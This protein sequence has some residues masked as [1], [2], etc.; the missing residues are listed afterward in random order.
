MLN[1]VYTM[2][3]VSAAVLVCSCAQSVDADKSVYDE[4]IPA[5]FFRA[6]VSDTKT[7]LKSGEKIFWLPSDKLSIYDGTS[8][9]T[10]GNDLTEASAS[11]DFSV[12]SGSVAEGDVSYAALYPASALYSWN[13]SGYDVSF[14]VPAVQTAEPGAIADGLDLLL[15]RSDSRSLSFTH[16]MSALKFTIDENSPYITG[17]A[18]TASVKLAARFGYKYSGSIE[19]RAS[20]SNTVT[21]KMEDDGVF[22]EGDYYIMIPAR[23]YSAALTVTFTDDLGNTAERTISAGKT[24]VAGTIYP[25]GTVSGLDLHVPFDANTVSAASISSELESK[26]SDFRSAAKKPAKTNSVWI[27]SS[28]YNAYSDKAALAARLSLLGF[29]SVYLSPGAAKINTPADD[30]KTFICECS[31]YRI[32]VFYSALDDNTQFVSYN[33]AAVN[34]LLAFN[35]A[36]TPSQRFAGLAAD[37]E[38]QSCTASGKPEGLTYTWASANYGI[39]GDNDNLLAITLDRLNSA[40]EPLHSAALSL[41]E[42]IHYNFQIY[43]NAGQLSNGAVSSFLTDCDFVT[44]MAYFTDK[45]SIWEKAEPCLIASSED[46]SVSIAVSVKD[47][48]TGSLYPN[49]WDN[50][51]VVLGYLNTEAGTYS[52]FRGLDI[53]GF[54]DFMTLYG[55]SPV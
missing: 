48:G 29:K 41:G 52:S 2:L 43:Q 26:A 54:A 47:G 11:A 1:R 9:A 28:A 8:T 55:A 42:A 49:G 21:L 33:P 40:S 50:L 14:T 32:K 45:N 23:K 46:D 39:G 20:G 7:V 27:N 22:P 25:M 34:R 4:D 17:I 44:I 18:V 53:F 12:E 24:A 15:A 13:E 51:L 16:I 36:V 30:L 19:S 31:R 10:L 35:E 3:S 6:R 5:G 38:P 37:L